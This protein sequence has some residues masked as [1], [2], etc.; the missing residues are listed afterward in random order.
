MQVRNLPEAQLQLLTAQV[1]PHFL[2]NTLNTISSLIREKPE[3]AEKIVDSLASMFRK[4]LNL[5]D[6]NLLKLE[7]EIG[8]VKDYLT[9]EKARFGERLQIKW[10]IENG[11]ENIEIPALCIQTLIENS[12]KHGISKEIKKG[13]IEISIKKEA[14]F[15]KILITDNG[16]GFNLEKMKHG[17]GLI[18]IQSRFL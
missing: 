13:I 18:N 9:I 14:G 5:S 4:T 6:K 11:T 2:F 16:S 7:E 10:N 17:H 12:I 1:H 15:L 3:L 8:L